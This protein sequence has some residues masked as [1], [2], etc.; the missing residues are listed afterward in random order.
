MARG[1]SLLPAPLPPCIDPTALL[2]WQYATL[3]GNKKKLEEV[4]AIL[5]AGHPLP[6]AVQPAALELPELQVGVGMHSA[7]AQFESQCTCC[8]AGQLNLP[9]QLARPSFQARVQM[10]LQGEPE[11]IAAQKCRLAAR[12]LGAAGEPGGSTC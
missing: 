9:M 2:A 4:V 8:S 12:Q 3:A 1:A 7:S 10:L 6:F 5:E 11:E